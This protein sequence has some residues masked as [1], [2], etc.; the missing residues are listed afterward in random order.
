MNCAEIVKL[1]EDKKNGVDCPSPLFFNFSL[2]TN[3]DAL[4]GED[5]VSFNGIKNNNKVFSIFGF[6]L[7]KKLDQSIFDESW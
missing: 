4:N 5:Y 7:N 6:V 2:S 3:T 1:F